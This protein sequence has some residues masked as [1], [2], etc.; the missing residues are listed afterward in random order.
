MSLKNIRKSFNYIPLLAIAIILGGIYLVQPHFQNSPVGAALNCAS[1][2][3]VRCVFVYYCIQAARGW[4]RELEF[5][6]RDLFILAAV[7]LGLAVA[8]CVGLALFFSQE[9]DIKI[10]DFATFWINTVELRSLIDHS[11]IHEVVAAFRRTAALEYTYVPALPL[12]LAGY[13]FGLHYMGY[14]QSIFVLYYLPACFFVS[15]LAMRLVRRAGK[16]TSRSSALTLCLCLCLLS[17]GAAWPLLNGYVDIIGVFVIMVMMNMTLD[18]DGTEFEWRKI[19]GLALLSTLAVLSRRFYAFYIIGFF[20]SFGAALLV[21]MI[22][23]QRY[24][25]RRLC[26]LA[27]TMALIAG[28]ASLVFLL[29]NPALFRVFLGVDY[30]QAYSAFKHMTTVQNIAVHARQTGWLWFLLSCLGAYIFFTIDS[31]RLLCFRIIVAPVVAFILFRRVQDMN[32]HHAYIIIS[33]MML[34]LCVF[35]LLAVDFIRARKS[36]GARGGMTV[37][38]GILLVAYGSNFLLAFEPRLSTIADRLQPVTTTIRSYPKILESYDAIMAVTTELKERIGDSPE[39]AYVGTVSPLLSPE[40]IV[41]SEMPAKT[42]AVDFVLSSKNVD[43]RDGFPSQAFLADYVLFQY[44]FFEEFQNRQEVVYQLFD[45]IVNSPLGQE[46]YRLEKTFPLAGENTV[47]LYHKIKET[48]PE[49]VGDFE[50]RLREKYPDNP[51]IYTPS[52]FVAFAKLLS[53]PDIRFDMSIDL[54]QFY[55]DKRAGGDAAMRIGY[56]S[57]FSTLSFRVNSWVGDLV[58]V[59]RNQDGEI[60]RNAIGG[61]QNREVSVDIAGSEHLEIVFTGADEENSTA[62]FFMLVN[63][64]LK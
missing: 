15:V 38:A 56:T 4:L 63:P 37:V 60:Y 27:G 25:L 46:Y 45:L 32:N 61:A 54:L 11:S 51:F 35:A 57:D 16:Y 24:S 26:R 48:T 28:T 5:S 58:L 21:D 18:W 8:G 20:F 47:R 62:G 12:A 17:T 19:L 31:V 23:S 30:A 2:A 40:Y 52:H 9:K 55:F 59:V 13:V 39:R 33:A 42:S 53:P 1:D 50:N 14:C 43:L 3:L 64:E 6:R 49:L 34:F 44:P 41:R 7:G 22:V 36:A 10:Y 29:L